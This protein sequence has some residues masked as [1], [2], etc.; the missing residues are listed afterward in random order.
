MVADVM[1]SGSAQSGEGISSLSGGHGPPYRHHSGPSNLRKKDSASS[2]PVSRG[3]SSSSPS[4]AH[5]LGKDLA[6]ASPSLRALSGD[7]SCPACSSSSAVHH[8][9]HQHLHR[10]SS[11]SQHSAAAL[12]GASVSHQHHQATT[13]TSTS[14]PG[15]PASSC[16]RNRTDPRRLE[17]KIN[18]VGPYP[19]LP[20]SP[21]SSVVS[22]GGSGAAPP[23]GP[24]SGPPVPLPAHGRYYPSSADN[25]NHPP[26]PYTIARARQRSRRVI[27]NV[28]GVKHEV[29]WRT[30]DRMPHT[31]LGKLRECSC[32]EALME[33]CDDY[34]LTENEFFFD[35]HPR[36]FASILNFYRTGRLHLV[37]EMC[38]LSFSEDLEYWGVDELY[39]ESCCQHRYHQKKEHV[40]EEIRKE[41]ESIRQ[42]DEDDF[43]NGYCSHWRQKVWDLLEKP[44]TS[45]AARRFLFS[46]DPG[47]QLSYENDNK[48]TELG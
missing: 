46:R 7:P 43:G 37:E 8:H 18:T 9:P 3:P 13:P 23:S 28:G 1:S 20:P 30:L 35:R 19:A 31:R 25:P 34:N 22:M 48:F 4:S 38:V 10:A 40:Y 27:L 42:R 16:L 39:L 44:T 17:V 41:A 26:D 33:L 5:D 45:M 29:L 11:S 24:S 2:G 36:A 21:T 12:G 15:V 32:H 47:S 14:T 6:P